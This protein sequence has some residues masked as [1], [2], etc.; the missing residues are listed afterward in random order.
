MDLDKAREF[1]RHNHHAVMATF[2]EDGRL[3]MSPVFV[4]VDPEGYLVISSRET[5]I[6]TKNLYKNPQVFLTVVPDA[7][8]GPWAQIEGR[9]QVV[10]LPDAMDHLVRYY[11]DLNGEH[12][13]WD[14]Y[15]AAMIRDKRVI[16]RVEPTRAG[17]DFKG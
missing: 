14:E 17:P 7:F 9:A 5:A 11:R 1:V 6:K 13:D 2:H 4:G 16:I 8:V 10:S 15:R 12:P 3:Q